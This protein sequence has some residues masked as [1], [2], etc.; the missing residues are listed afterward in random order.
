MTPDVSMDEESMKLGFL[1]DTAKSH[2]KTAE[3]C[4]EKL[5]AHTQGLNAMVRDQ[6][7]QVMVEELKTVQAET[8]GVI[9]ALRP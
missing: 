1:M 5:K 8:Q 9:T 4:L 2:Q 3:G 7:R 6:I